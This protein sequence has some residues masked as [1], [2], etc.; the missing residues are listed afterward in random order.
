M[1]ARL[2]TIKSRLGNTDPNTHLGGLPAGGHIGPPLRF[3]VSGPPDRQCDALLRAVFPERGTPRGGRAGGCDR[4][5]VVAPRRPGRGNPLPR[6]RTPTPC[7]RYVHVGQPH[8]P[9]VQP[10]ALKRTCQ[11]PR[12]VAA[13]QLGSDAFSPFPLPQRGEGGGGLGGYI[14]AYRLRCRGS[15]ASRSPSP[16]RLKASTVRKIARP[17]KTVSH[18][19]P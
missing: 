10:A 9:R 14:P 8:Q 7:S 4:P 3:D 19:A 1:S 15:S 18:Q 17:G 13:D 5:R 16:I 11:P 2:P 6:P 12:S